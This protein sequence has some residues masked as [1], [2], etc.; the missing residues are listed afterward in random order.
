MSLVPVNSTETSPKFV[1]EWSGTRVVFRYFPRKATLFIRMAAN[2]IKCILVVAHF[3]WKCPAIYR[4]SWRFAAH[5]ASF[6]MKRKFV[7]THLSISSIYPVDENKV[8]RRA[9]WRMADT[10]MKLLAISAGRYLF[11]RFFLFSFSELRKHVRVLT[12]I[13]KKRVVRI[14]TGS[15]WYSSSRKRLLWLCYAR[16]LHDYNLDICSQISFN[17]FQ[18]NRATTIKACNSVNKFFRCFMKHARYGYESL[19]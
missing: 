1:G 4:V 2:Q 13:H 3:S 18:Y 10:L 11:F 5:F 14:H 17:F 12:M 8:K 7:S 16:K 9:R 15:Q 6:S 19:Q